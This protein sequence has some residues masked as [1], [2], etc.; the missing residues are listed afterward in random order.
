MDALVL[1][2]ALPGDDELDSVD[3]LLRRELAAAGWRSDT[4]VLRDLSIAYCQGCF[5]CYTRS[6]GLC[7]TRDAGRDVAAAVIRSDMVVL[8]TAITFGG[9][10]SELKKAMDRIAA[11]VSPLFMRIE[12]EYHH[13]ARYER[14]PVILGVGMARQDGSPEEERIFQELVARNALNLHAPWY[15]ARVLHR[16]ED[17]PTRLEVLR[18]AIVGHGRAA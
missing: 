15:G 10:S 8:L 14:Y 4:L 2:G 17:P 12:G 16:G 1:N 9:Y 6:P 18:P 5:D 7:K 3:Q 11:L 13:Q